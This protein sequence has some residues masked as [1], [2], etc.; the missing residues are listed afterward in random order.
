MKPQKSEKGSSGIHVALALLIILTAAA[1]GGSWY[2]L[3]S[4]RNLQQA[5]E[6]TVSQ[7]QA[8]AALYDDQKPV[9]EYRMEGVSYQIPLNG[10]PSDSSQAPAPSSQPAQNQPVVLSGDYILPDVSTRFYSQSELAGL[11]KQQ[12][13]LARNEIYARLGRKFKNA[14]LDKYFRGKSW[15]QPLYEPD[16]FDAKGDGVF[17]QYELANRN[18]IVEIERTMK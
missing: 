7:N 8:Q 9:E 4:E 3:S 11:S 18:L 1:W 15:Y 16:A 13:Y 10:A 17:N 6:N 12:L 2:V 14:D 5:A